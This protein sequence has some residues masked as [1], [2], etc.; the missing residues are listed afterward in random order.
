L[1]SFQAR[2]QERVLGVY[3]GRGM[4]AGTSQAVVLSHGQGGNVPPQPLNVEIL[5]QVGDV[6]GDV[7]FFSF[8][9]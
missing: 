5:Y 8:C 3:L 1:A 2:Y 6:Y 7:Y 4:V 9:Y